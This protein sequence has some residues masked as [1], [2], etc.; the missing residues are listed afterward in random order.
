MAD[1]ESRSC[2][3]GEAS[4]LLVLPFFPALFFTEFRS[5]QGRWVRS[6]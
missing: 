4:F 5:D 3:E 2:L 1:G 6:L